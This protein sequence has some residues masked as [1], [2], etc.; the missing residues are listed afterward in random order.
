[1]S[2]AGRFGWDGYKRGC[3]L[4]DGNGCAQYGINWK[5]TE[6]KGM[7]ESPRLHGKEF[8]TTEFRTEP[9]R[10]GQQAD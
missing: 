5:G 10:T 6:H 4:C 7:N 8:T 1:M 2:C 3:S 9:G